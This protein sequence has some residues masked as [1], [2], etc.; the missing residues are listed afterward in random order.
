MELGLR[1]TALTGFDA[2]PLP[3]ELP[4]ADAPEPLAAEPVA[5]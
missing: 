1:T 4:G 3:Y 5:G 2:L